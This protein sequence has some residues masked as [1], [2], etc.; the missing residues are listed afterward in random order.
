[1]RPRD[2]GRASARGPWPL[3]AGGHEPNEFVFTL[4]AEGG[5][6]PRGPGASAGYQLRDDRRKQSFFT[7]CVTQ[8]GD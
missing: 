5:K 8:G 6:G 3:A 7:A 4:A 2:D 1:M